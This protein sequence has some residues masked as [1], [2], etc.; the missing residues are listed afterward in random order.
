MAEQAQARPF[1]R[2]RAG[3]AATGA[4]R[5]A[6]DRLALAARYLGIV[7]ALGVLAMLYMALIYA[8]T[9]RTQGPAQRIFYIHFGSA[10]STYIAYGVTC[11]ASIAFLWRRSEQWDLLARSSAEVGVLLNTILLVTGSIWGKTIWGAWWAWDA[12][13]TSTLILWFIYAGYLMLRAYGGNTPQIARSAA[14]VAIIGCLDIPIINQSVNWWRTQHPS[15][16]VERASP[17]LPPEMLQ[18]M[19][20]GLLAFALIYAYLTLQRFRVEQLSAQV[21][22]LQQDALFL[23]ETTAQ[24]ED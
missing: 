9:E 4:A 10:I 3:E 12:R 7:T 16:I 11:L 19:F 15:P 18:A 1:P 13:L 2:P 20:V 23:D 6:P 14:V 22:R 5:T 8:P 24:R 21:G 17:A